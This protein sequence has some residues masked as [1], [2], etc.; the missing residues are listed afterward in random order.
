M[1]DFRDAKAMARTL[2]AALT[3][4]GL[5]I[6]V[7]Q[8]LELIAEAFGVADWNTLAAAIRREA[9]TPR[10]NASP[11]PLPTADWARR[12]FSA[13][14]EFSAALELTLHRALAHANQREHDEPWLV[15]GAGLL[16]WT[17]KGYSARTRRPQGVQALVL[18]PPSLV[19]VLRAG[20]QPLVPLLHPSA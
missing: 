9:L 4:K 6:T 13:G 15:R 1:R 5:K 19:E 2:R 16:R 3:A 20:W 17:A 18:T 7:S 8:S 12:R 14:V 10:E 11:L